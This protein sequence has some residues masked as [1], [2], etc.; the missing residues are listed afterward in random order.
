MTGKDLRIVFMG[1]PDFAVASLK[2][3]VEGGYN[4]V[5]VITAPDKPA[6]RGRQL[7]QSAVKQ[8]AVAQNLKVLQPE[9]LKNPEFIAA[10]EALKA[11]LQVVVAFRM[12]PEVVW[13]MPRLGTFNLHGSLLPQYRGAA[14][15]NW[16]VINGEKE[17]GVTT[18]L[19][20]HEIDTGAILFREKI[21]IGDNDN[22]GDIHDRLMDIGARLVVKTVDALGEGRYTTVEQDE[23]QAGNLKPAPKIFKEDCK[24]DWEKPAEEVRNLI[25]GLS[26]YPAAWTELVDG[27]GKLM[28]LKIFKAEIEPNEGLAPGTLETDGKNSF[29]IAAKDGWLVISDLQL[30]GKKR[31]STADFLRGVHEPETFKLP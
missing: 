17:T 8:Y 10:L 21:T 24:I 31:M 19:L 3:L 26:P 22:V 14:P 13:R 1:T 25:R 16:A 9:K 18:F 2:A 28:S 29:K 5:G 27:K 6:G 30:S 23:I 11:D 20:S 4:I 7:Q 15:L 12:L